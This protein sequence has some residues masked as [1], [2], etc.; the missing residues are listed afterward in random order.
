MIA[1]NS[2]PTTAASEITAN[3]LDEISI[4]ELFK[5]KREIDAFVNA[6]DAAEQAFCNG[7]SA[8]E[9][10]Q[11]ICTE[12]A[13]ALKSRIRSLAIAMGV[14]ADFLKEYNATCKRNGLALTPVQSPF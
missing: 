2:F 7:D 1:L 13:L 12:K 10:C 6:Q 9:D 3:V 14:H 11:N 8:Y 5:L 4:D